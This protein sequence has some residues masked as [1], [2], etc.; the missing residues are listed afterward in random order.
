MTTETEAKSRPILFSGPMVR[1]ILEGR[2]TQ[3][4]RVIKPQPPD[5]WLPSE[6]TDIHK[7]WSD[8]SFPMQNGEPI[9]KGWGVVNESGDW[10]CVCPHGKPGDNLWV[11]ETWQAL[12]RRFGVEYNPKVY[13]DPDWEKWHKYYRATDGGLLPDDSHWRPSIFMPRWVCRIELEITNVRVE[14][15]QSISE[16]DAI[17]EGVYTNKQ[18]VEKLG[19]PAD[20]KLSGS[21]VDKYRIVWE[22]INGKKYP[23]VSNCWVW[24][25]SFRRIEK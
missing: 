3:T 11:R 19:L 18:A 13:L 25:I 6:M 2:K 15:L 22:S 20:T 9:I 17:A 24:V 16:V 23:W 12:T 5:E 4:R 21:C 8:G 14:R 10:G 7:M 1:A